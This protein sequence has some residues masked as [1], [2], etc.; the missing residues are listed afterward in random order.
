MLS[1]FFSPYGAIC[2]LLSKRD[3]PSDWQRF[4]DSLDIHPSYIYR[5]QALL[6]MTPLLLSQLDRGDR[7]AV[8][9]VG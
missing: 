8:P 1:T 9:F 2:A 4:S 7:T 6:K 3:N 5:A